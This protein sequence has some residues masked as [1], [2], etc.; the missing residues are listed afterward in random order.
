MKPRVV[1]ALSGGVDSSVAAYLLKQQGY[2]VVGLVLRLLDPAAGGPQA[3]AVARAQEVAQKLGIPLEVWDLRRAFQEK[4]IR[5]FVEGYRRGWTPN[6]CV[7]C[8]RVIKFAFLGKALRRFQAEIVATGHY[9]RA[10]DHEIHRPRDR[11]KDQTYFL[12]WI[13]RG[14]L[15]RIQ[16]PLG[17]LLKEEVRELAR[18][19]GLKETVGHESQDI[20]FV[21][22]DYREFLR[23]RLGDRP[24]EIVDSTGRILGHHR[25]YYAFT[26]GQRRGLGV[27]AGRRLYV[28]RVDAGS[29]RVVV[30][31]REELYRR[32]VWVYGFRWIVDPEPWGE[33][34]EVQVRY[35][36]RPVPARVEAAGPLARIHFQEP[37]WN[38]APGQFAVAYRE[39]QL[40]G[41]GLIVPEGSQEV[42]KTWIPDFLEDP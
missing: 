4:V 26:P 35:R 20:C 39:S 12:A 13:P 18:R 36:T 22:K 32:E 6:P 10:V 38:P 5:F 21:P 41:G 40:L 33:P 42:P 8:N 3:D 28:L 15:G 23:P 7:L 16:F 17:N 30:G 29:H 9:A 24:G 37:V 19:L 34:V 14:L 1:V 25:A 31:P 2:A 11:Q 27:S